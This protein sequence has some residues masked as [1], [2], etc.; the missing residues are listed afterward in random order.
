MYGE[1]HR[2]YSEIVVQEA[3]VVTAFRCEGF[4]A[5][6]MLGRVRASYLSGDPITIMKYAHMNNIFPDS[7][8]I[9]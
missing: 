4:D 7:F 1:K 8:R 2:V 9:V 3:I 6:L 5:F